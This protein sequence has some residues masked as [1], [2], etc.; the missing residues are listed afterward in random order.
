MPLK[1]ETK[2]QKVG[3]TGTL[4]TSI[5][6][7]I[8]KALGLHKGDRITMFLDEKNRIVIEKSEG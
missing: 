3:A 5:P 7:P 2:I 4:A 1:L 8:V 6:K